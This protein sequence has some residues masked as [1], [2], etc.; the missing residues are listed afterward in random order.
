MS[1]WG[2]HP[3]PTV[4]PLASMGAWSFS[5]SP[6]TTRPMNSTTERWSR[7]A[8]TAA[9]S[10]ASL[11][12][13]PSQRAAAT[14]ADSVTRT[15]SSAR[16]RLVRDND[17]AKAASSSA[18]RLRSAAARWRARIFL[19]DLTRC[20]LARISSALS[21][22][23]VSGS[24]TFRARGAGRVARA[25][26]L[27][28]RNTHLGKNERGARATTRATQARKRRS[29]GARA[30]RALDVA[31]WRRA[32]SSRGSACVSIRRERG[33][34]C[35]V[36]APNRHAVTP[37]RLLSQNR[38]ARASPPSPSRLTPLASYSP[39][40]PLLLLLLLLLLTRLRL[41]P[42]CIAPFP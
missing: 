17:A 8:S 30:R 22:G 3:A 36:A 35:H 18:P 16:L 27:T 10:A 32:S 11:S 5:P 15:I 4:S 20:T 24:G 26:R 14:A 34:K 13:L 19:S 25:R 39:L 33:T 2:R 23:R 42:A 31:R 40:T 37:A 6:M 21:S 38:N 28:C 9:A 29:R 41:R 7:M 12:P 1:A